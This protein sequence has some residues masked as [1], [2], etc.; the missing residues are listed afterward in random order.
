M[1]WDTTGEYLASVS[2]D[3]VR[4]WT[5]GSGGKGECMHELSCSGN[6][7]RTCV[8]HPTFSSLLV[9]GC[10]EASHYSSAF[11]CNLLICFNAINMLS[12]TYMHTCMHTCVSVG[13]FVHMGF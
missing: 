4:V 5:I 2:D 1:C 9:I 13:N 6:R 11:P 12:F 7:F 8:F 10:Y 3:L